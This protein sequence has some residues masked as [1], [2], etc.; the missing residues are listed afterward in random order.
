MR[1]ITLAVSVAMVLG[2]AIPVLA[3]GPAQS[4]VGTQHDLTATGSGP[5][6]S[7]Q[8]DSCFFCHA[9]HNVTNTLGALWDHTL[10]TQTYNTY[11]STTYD[12]GTQVPSAGS[13]KLCLSCH[14]GTVAV[15]QTI[16]AGLISTS[17]SLTTADNLGNW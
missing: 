2:A 12:S 15:G 17:G 14:D 1:P 11:A 16:A 9:P 10:S 3:M 13:S 6:S 8:T 4:V 5:V 7:T